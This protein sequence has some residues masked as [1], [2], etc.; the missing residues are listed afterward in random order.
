MKYKIWQIYE[1]DGHGK[2]PRLLKEPLDE[3][4]NTILTPDG[5]ILRIVSDED[6]PYRFWEM[7]EKYFKVE[8]LE[9]T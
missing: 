9:S 5:K 1:Y 7:N 8:I 3:T 4:E 2:E 6:E